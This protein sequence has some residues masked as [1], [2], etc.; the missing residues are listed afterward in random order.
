MQR[1]SRSPAAWTSS[2]STRRRRAA[3]RISMACR[4]RWSATSGG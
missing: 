3:R 2:A 4:D 1:S